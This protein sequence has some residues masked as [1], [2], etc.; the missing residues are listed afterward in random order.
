[1]V[2]GRYCVALGSYFTT[3]IGQY[4]DVIL[5][6]GTV[7]PCILG[8]QKSD[9]HT[10][11]KYHVITIRGIHADRSIMEFIIDPAIFVSDR[12]GSLSNYEPEWNSPVVQ[13]IVYDINVFDK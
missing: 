2:D 6:N 5:E 8:D 10:D 13:V 9:A 7:L 11:L 12:T 3:Q 4:I 1:M